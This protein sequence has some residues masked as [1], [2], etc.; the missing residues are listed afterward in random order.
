MKRSLITTLIIG[1]AV[2][3]IVVALHATKVIAGFETVAGQLVTEYAGATRVVGEKWQYVLVLVIAL[4][5]ARLEQ[6]RGCGTMARLVNIRVIAGGTVWPGVGLLS[7]SRIFSAGAVSPGAPVCSP[8]RRRV[9]GFF[10]QEPLTS[11]PHIVC[12]S[13]L[14]R[15]ISASWRRENFVRR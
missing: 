13:R 14:Q 10:T 7:L 8:R 11:N 3:L 1:V 5:V 12:R 2:T 9:V 15:A 6:S 4:G